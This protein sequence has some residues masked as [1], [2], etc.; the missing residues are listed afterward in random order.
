[1]RIKDEEAMFQCDACQGLITPFAPLVVDGEKHY[2]S[3]NCYLVSLIGQHCHQCNERF[4]GRDGSISIGS[5][6]WFCSKACRHAFE[7][8]MSDAL[9]SK[10][11]PP[12]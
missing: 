3:P 2:C 12:D 11:V 5:H 8:E 1:M 7:Q 4:I 6:V 9:K 10:I